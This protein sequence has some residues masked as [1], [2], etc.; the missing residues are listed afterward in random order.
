[1]LIV[2]IRTLLIYILLLLAMRLMGKRQIGEL[3]VTDLVI[4]LLLSDIATHPIVDSDNPLSHALIPIITLLATEV[5]LSWILSRFPKLKALG[6]ARPNILIRNGHI[7]RRE[8]DRLR[9]S[10]DELIS[11]LR[12]KDVSNIDD[13]A[14]AI[15][16]QNGK[17]SVI[18]RA[19]C[20]PPTREDLSISASEGGIMHILISR[21]VVNRHNLRL[22]SKE[23]GWLDDQLQ[24]R[25]CTVRDVFLMTVDDS[26]EIYLSLYRDTDRTAE[27]EEN[28]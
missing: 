16:E 17:I 4:T 9:I 12:Q 23:S 22:L 13:V 24:R 15:L 14:Y 21:G 3:E 6:S 5:T 28:A 10:S 1:M 2:F 8:L 19:P 25:H 20:R 27:S 7:D 26:G 18:V 11:E